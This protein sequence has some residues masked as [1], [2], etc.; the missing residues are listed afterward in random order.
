VEERLGGSKLGQECQK[1][2]E[3]LLKK[4]SVDE[5]DGLAS[6]VEFRWNGEYLSDYDVYQE[7]TNDN[8][9]HTW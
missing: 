4:T 7:W 3:T 6:I 1:G 8:S 2:G 5:E 9:F